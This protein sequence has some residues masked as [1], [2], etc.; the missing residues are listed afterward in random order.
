[1]LMAVM[2]VTSVFISDIIGPTFLQLEIGGQ[3]K[4]PYEINQFT[5]KVK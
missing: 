3:S 2:S 5:G 4:E 1:M